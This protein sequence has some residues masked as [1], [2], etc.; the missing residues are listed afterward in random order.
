M[1]PDAPHPALVAYDSA[2]KDPGRHVP[3]E[4]ADRIATLG[5]SI[6]HADVLARFGLPADDAP[7]AWDPRAVDDLDELVAE[8][9]ARV[10]GEVHRFAKL[11]I[12]ELRALA[13]W[14]GPRRMRSA[15]GA[16]ARVAERAAARAGGV[17]PKRPAPRP[18]VLV[19]PGCRVF[20]HFER[21]TARLRVAG[22]F[23]APS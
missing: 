14:K 10:V 3:E 1:L 9:A 11:G 6:P 18:R 16:L 19:L 20:L 2:P 22:V 8:H 13:P 23:R 12:G 4:I 5:A 17:L 15:F 7:I 21:E